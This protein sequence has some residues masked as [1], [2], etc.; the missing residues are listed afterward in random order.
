MQRD[1]RRL[2]VS[3]NKGK[4]KKYQPDLFPPKML[5]KG[6]GCLLFFLGAAFFDTWCGIQTRRM[7]YEIEQVRMQHES[8]LNYQKK[9]K[10]EKARLTS[11]QVLRRYATGELELQTPKPEQIIVV[12]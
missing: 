4:N 12:P 9:L 8:L 1:T 10:I 3:E 5:L 6:M 11:P 7:G 2:T